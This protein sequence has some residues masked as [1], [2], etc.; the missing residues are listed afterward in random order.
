MSDIL[1]IALLISIFVNLFLKSKLNVAMW[2]VKYNHDRYLIA[3]PNCNECQSYGNQ[4]ICNHCYGKAVNNF[5]K[6]D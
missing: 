1:F 6:K 4:E 2:L 5:R 3:H